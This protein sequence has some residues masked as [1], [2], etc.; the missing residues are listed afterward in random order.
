MALRRL[1]PSRAE[2]AASSAVLVLLAA[3]IVWLG[4]VQS[5]LSPAVVVATSP[6]PP[7]A[8][9]VASADGRVF[10]TAA[11]LESLAGA[12]PGGPVESYDPET[13]SDRIDGKAELYLAANF[14]EMSVRGFSLPSGAHLDVYLYAQA[15]PRDAYAVLSAQRRPG[16]TPSDVSPDAYATQNALYFNKGNHYAELSADRADAATLDALAQAA[17]D[18]A[19]RLPAAEPAADGAG[20]APDPKTLFPAAGLDA[21]SLRL[22][23]SDAMGLAGFSNVYTA[24]YAMPSGAATAFLAQRDTPEAAAADAKAFAGFLAENGYAPQQ[25]QGLPQGAVLLAA[26]GSFEIIWTSGG[27]VAGV[28]DAVSR[29]AALELAAAL[30]AGLKDAVK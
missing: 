18:L 6:P 3:A 23:A 22:A 24:D 15:S 9:P 11:F 4:A 2:S 25:A 13:L 12:T 26:P 19:G 8:A 7:A 28:H 17:R 5:R 21:A 14:Q 20:A 27:Y 16:A 10:E 1:G 29:E 30:A